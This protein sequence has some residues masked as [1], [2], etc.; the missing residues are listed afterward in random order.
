MSKPEYT[1]D[2]IDRLIE[3]VTQHFYNDRHDLYMSN[4]EKFEDDWK[5][6]KLDEIDLE[7]EIEE[8][9]TEAEV[10]G[11]MT[12]E[13]DRTPANWTFDITDDYLELEDE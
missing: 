8:I 1:Q 7:R 10:V 5:M 12:V 4:K 3:E 6:F 9:E 2:N 11:G 13:I